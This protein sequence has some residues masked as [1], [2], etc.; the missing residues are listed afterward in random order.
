MLELTVSSFFKEICSIHLISTTEYWPW[1]TAAI[2]NLRHFTHWHALAGWDAGTQLQ[3]CPYTHSGARHSVV[4]HAQHLRL[5][6]KQAALGKHSFPC[7]GSGNVQSVRQRVLDWQRHTS[8]ELQRVCTEK[9][10]TQQE[11]LKVYL[12]AGVCFYIWPLSIWCGFT[13]L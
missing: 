9:P 10:L 6:V 1:G 12:R 7:P 2:S 8:R 3:S 11:I 5:Q 13:G 4:T